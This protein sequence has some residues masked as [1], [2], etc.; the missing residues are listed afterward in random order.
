[1][2]SPSSTRIGRAFG[3][4]F[5]EIPDGCSG[6]RALHFGLKRAQVA[7]DHCGTNLQRRALF[8]QLERRRFFVGSCWKTEGPI[9]DGEEQ[10]I[11]ERKSSKS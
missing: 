4:S 3:T 5:H 8:N 11:K 9:V 7:T 2:P 1:M 10:R 6:L